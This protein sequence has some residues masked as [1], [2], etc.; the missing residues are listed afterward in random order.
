MIEKYKEI[1]KSFRPTLVYNLGSEA[2]FFSEFNNMILAMLYCLNNRIKF[3][4]YSSNKNFFPNEGWTDYF[5]SFCDEVSSKKHSTYNFRQLY[6]KKSTLFRFKTAL[7][8][9]Q[10]NIDYLTYEL[11][12]Y[13]HCKDFENT[14]FNI[15]RLGI[16]GDI[17]IAS[18]ALINMVW[19]FTPKI[20]DEIE[21]ITKTLNLPNYY[22]GIQIRGGDKKNESNLIHPYKYI[23]LLSNLSSCINYF[24]L[25]DDYS[26]FK[27]VKDKY[28]DYNF[29]TLCESSEKGYF[30]THFSSMD[31]DS[32]RKLLVKLF[33]SINILVKADFNVCT[34]SSNPG[35]FLGMVL[36][37]S[38]IIS[39]E[40][41]EWTIW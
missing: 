30:H 14:F 4:L 11:W 6:S 20:F 35:M 15:P 18:A 27:N 3:V 16:I 13:F 25:T 36:S 34:Y 23:D 9:L 29:Y 26:I 19:K 33:A 28:V 17:R 22:V 40:P 2:G 5:I 37:D 39:L 1:N 31:I 8:K 41:K 21:L 32:K 10:N 24:I 12:P 38:K 7:F